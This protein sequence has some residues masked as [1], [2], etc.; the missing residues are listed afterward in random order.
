MEKAHPDVWGVLL[1]V[2]DDGRLTD[3][4]GR[5]V[6]FKNTVVIMTSN[7]GS[8]HLL[9]LTTKNRPEI[10]A[11]VMRELQST[12]R[13]E[14]INR[15]DEIIFFEPLGQAQ[16]AQIVKIQVHRFEKLLAERQLALH[17]SDQA[18]AKVAEAGYDPVYGAR[19][20]K[21]A[22]QKLV[23]DP[24]ANRLLAGE[25]QPGDLIEADVSAGGDAAI[26]FR[27]GQPRQKVTA[28]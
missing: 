4:Q 17:L 6:D 1:Q 27:R 3:G 2:L 10:E 13:P 16:L 21:R 8:Q 9:R 14:F 20:L 28:A 7:A 25:F 24:L 19:P 18:V 11:Q 15:I 22:L 23:I 12:F 26:T 5:T